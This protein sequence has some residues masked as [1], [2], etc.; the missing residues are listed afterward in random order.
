MY[1]HTTPLSIPTHARGP[2]DPDDADDD[3]PAAAGATN[4]EAPPTPGI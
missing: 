1:A 2:G 4:D 3:G